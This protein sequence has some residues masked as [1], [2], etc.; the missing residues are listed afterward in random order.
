[1]QRLILIFL[2]AFLMLSLA[3]CSPDPLSQP[4]G[5]IERG[6]YATGVTQNAAQPGQWDSGFNLMIAADNQ[7]VGLLL[8][9]TTTSGSLS[10]VIQT[11]DGQTVWR[12]APQSGAVTIRETI[13]NLAQGE[14]LLVVAWDD[15]LSATFDLY[16][17][18]G[19][20]VSIP[21]V[22]PDALLGG[23]GMILVAV[24]FLVYGGVKRLGWRY[25][26]LG[27][28]SWLVTVAVKFIIAVPLNPILYKLLV[29][30]EA[31]GIGDLIF[32]LY[33]GV[34][35]GITEI[36]MV[37][38]LLRVTRLGKVSWEKALGFGIG[39]GAFEALLLGLSSFGSTLAALLV[40]A[41]IPLS[42]MASLAVGNHL[43]VGLAPTWER[44]W[45][46][47]IHIL[48]NVLLF[49]GALTRKDRYFWIAFWFKSG[50]DAVAGYAQLTGIN[51]L[52]KMWTI[53]AIVALFGAA[54]YWGTWKIKH[55]YPTTQI[56]G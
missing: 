17:V 13:T 55:M 50:I 56:V 28:L 16:M 1:M 44:F 37:W 43:L 33:I 40:P 48:S 41:Q 45:T 47:W 25:I 22:K 39:F 15:A 23:G 24:G 32:D 51:S 54:G 46:V 49:Y 6:N 38:I 30:P 2:A 3:A 9:G 42:A 52:A 12:S 21:E 7:P 8:R 20:P 4:P 26:G 34:L 18:P 29:N 27:A 35:T 5:N 19:E 53:E 10:L 11:P 31:P 36:L 14:Y